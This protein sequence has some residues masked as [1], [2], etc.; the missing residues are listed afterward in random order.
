LLDL[1]VDVL[2]EA[3]WLIFSGTIVS[4]RV[5]VLSAIFAAAIALPL[6]IMRQ[7]RIAVVRTAALCWVEFFRGISTVVQLFWLFFALPFFGISLSAETAAV[8]GLGLVHG[9]YGSEVV[10]GAMQSIGRDQW[11]A[12]TALGFSRQTTLFSIVLPQAFVAML[13][14][15]GNSLVLLLKGTSIASIITVPELTFQSTLIVT[16]RP[17]AVIPVFACVLFIYYGI[18]IAVSFAVRLVERK[19]GGWR[20]RTA[21]IR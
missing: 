12:A 19:A 17:V 9:A 11:E 15:L 16:T 14:P 21:G 18:A 2:L 5:F 8:I 4:L 6:G 10:R 20:P 1:Q 3:R 13:P 7:S